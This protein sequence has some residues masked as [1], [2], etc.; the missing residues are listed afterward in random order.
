METFKLHRHKQRGLLLW[1]ARCLA[2]PLSA[3]AHTPKVLTTDQLRRPRDRAL[4]LAM[5]YRLRIWRAGHSLSLCL[6]G[7]AA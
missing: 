6:P 3:L 2:L 4:A 1:L 7:R 5:L